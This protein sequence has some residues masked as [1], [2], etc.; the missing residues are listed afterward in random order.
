MRIHRGHSENTEPC[1]LFAGLLLHWWFFLNGI[2]ETGVTSVGFCL[3]LLLQFR[4]ALSL[5]ATPCQVFPIVYQPSVYH[6][7]AFNFHIIFP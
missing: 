2:G 1:S 7:F 4:L 6:E 5:T 3:L